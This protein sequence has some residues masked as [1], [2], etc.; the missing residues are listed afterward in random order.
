MRVVHDQAGRTYA[1]EPIAKGIN[2]I[3]RED[4]ERDK[5]VGHI[6]RARQNCVHWNS[7]AALDPEFFYE[8]PQVF[9]F[10]EGGTKGFGLG[11]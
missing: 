4:V 9:V 8:A 7:I 3:C 6:R 5:K 10:T 2:R 1:S 11:L